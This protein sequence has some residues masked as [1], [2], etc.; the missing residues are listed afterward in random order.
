MKGPGVCSWHEDNN[1]QR[2]S[3]G[4]TLTAVHTNA[5]RLNHHIHHRPTFDFRKLRAKCRELGFGRVDWN[6]E[7]LF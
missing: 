2:T 6:T 3:I 7:L 1:L 5:L 4:V